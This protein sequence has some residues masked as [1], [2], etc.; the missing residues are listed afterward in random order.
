MSLAN[1]LSLFL[2]LSGLELRGDESRYVPGG[3]SELAS[4][5]LGVGFSGK[6]PAF[7]L[8]IPDSRSDAAGDTVARL[9]LSWMR[10]LWDGL[11]D[12]PEAR[13]VPPPLL[14]GLP[15]AKLAWFYG[16]LGFTPV[17]A[18]AGVVYGNMVGVSRRKIDNALPAITGALVQV[19]LPERFEGLLLGLLREEKGLAARVL[20][21]AGLSLAA[22][23]AETVRLVGAGQ[24][25]EAGAR[26][27]P[28]PAGPAPMQPAGAGAAAWRRGRGPWSAFPLSLPVFFVRVGGGLWFLVSGIKEA[29]VGS[30]GAAT[31]G[32][33]VGVVCGALLVAG[34]RRRDASV[35]M[36]FLLL[37]VSLTR[38]VRE[39][40]FNVAAFLLPGL[41][42]LLPGL[43]LS[44]DYDRWSVD[45]VLL[46]R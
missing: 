38:L 35:V 15:E 7:D 30:S 28:K 39:P 41:A 29:A 18:L 16:R 4:P 33:V 32:A 9:A 24:S 10:D 14:A 44:P 46:R 19:Q 23:R 5:R 21:D 42:L 1:L 8:Q 37:V 40:G 17:G 26:V 12:A 36:G 2:S 20:R 31:A 6:L 25:D 13:P 43:T 3:A 22:A 27:W 45:R 11:P 34:W